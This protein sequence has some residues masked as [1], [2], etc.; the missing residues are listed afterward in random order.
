M[1]IRLANK[2]DK[3]QILLMIKHFRDATPLP[4][5]TNYFNEKYLTTLVTHILAGRGLIVVAEKDN[6][7][8]G[9]I[10][11]FI[12]NNIWDPDLLVMNELCFWVE[13]EHRGGSIAYRMI[14]KYSELAANLC[15][16]KRI[17]LYTMSL[18]SNSP[19]LDYSRFGFMKTE[20]TWVGGLV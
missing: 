18:M 2:F 14:K 17:Q 16:E 4:I 1:L 3:D 15:D 10:I 8:V 9:M 6:Q 7:L 19:K 5:M 11:G 20:E 13:P 12:N